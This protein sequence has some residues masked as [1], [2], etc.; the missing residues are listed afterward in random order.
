MVS[1]HAETITTKPAEPSRSITARGVESIVHH[2]IGTR[3]H[4]Y[5]SPK[6][7][8]PRWFQPPTFPSGVCRREQDGAIQSPNSDQHR[9]AGALPGGRADRGSLVVTTLR[10]N[11]KPVHQGGFKATF[12]RLSSPPFLSAVYLTD[13]VVPLHR[14]RPSAFAE[15][16]PSARHSSP[17]AE[18]R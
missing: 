14:F 2:R 17:E 7:P 10:V 5:V 4:C 6:R 16:L 13:R 1:V 12:F 11:A 9:Q 3:S 18:S 8:K 15:L